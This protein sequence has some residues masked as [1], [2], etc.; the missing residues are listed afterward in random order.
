VSQPAQFALRSSSV[1]H[2]RLALQMPEQSPEGP[3]PAQVP[4]PRTEPRRPVP[5]AVRGPA[6]AFIWT[7]PEAETRPPKLIG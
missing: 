3:R 5:R 6:T 4:L 7:C 1:H 2:E